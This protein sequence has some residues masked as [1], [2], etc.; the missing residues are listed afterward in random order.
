MGSRVTR[1]RVISSLAAAVGVGLAGCSGGDGGDGGGNVVDMTNE[2]VFEPRTITVS[3]GDTVTWE[4][5]GT[6]GHS[7]TAYEDSIP[8]GAAY[9]ASGGFDAE[10]AARDAYT[11]GD[12]DAGDVPGGESY[13]QTFETAGTH[14]YFCIPHESADM[15][16][17]VEVE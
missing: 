10:Q 4:N 2:L 16:G 15:L 7:V 13:S 6:V 14:E 8:D 11:V 12:P 3:V 17:T 9:W 1:R 5:V